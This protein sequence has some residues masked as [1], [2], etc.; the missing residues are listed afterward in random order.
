[1]PHTQ[2]FYAN[3]T[4]SQGPVDLATL[5]G[6]QE[7]GVVSAQTLVWCQGMAGWQPLHQ[8]SAAIADGG[9]AAAD[10][11]AVPPAVAED[12]DPYRASQ[13]PVVAAADSVSGEGMAAYAAVV[14]N[15]FPIYRRRWR[16]DQG[17]AN[18]AGTWHWPGFLFGL[19]WMVYRKMYR[20]VAIWVGVLIASSVLEGLL[21]LPDAVSP[22]ITVGLAIAV[23]IHANGWYLA[24][25]QR[26]IESARALHPGS[27]AAQQA[28][29]ARRGGTS[30]G[31]VLLAMLLIGGLMFGLS[32]LP[33]G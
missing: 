12:G 11:V 16:L 24:H 1:M 31:A 33:D 13:V 22:F 32:L 4:Q 9:V 8:V 7:E 17:P 15:R 28:E 29:L 5:L 20:M 10:G 27:E 6:L 23:G 2:W 3:S 14:G 30:A 19:L 25:C 26:Q 18:A 21:G